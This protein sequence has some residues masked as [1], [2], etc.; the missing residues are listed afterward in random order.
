RKTS[1]WMKM[2]FSV[3]VKL[4]EWPKLSLMRIFQS[5]GISVLKRTSRKLNSRMLMAK[6]IRGSRIYWT[7]DEWECYPVGL[8]ENQKAGMTDEQCKELYRDFLA[9]LDLF[10]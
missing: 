1:V 4:R 9:D 7:W 10:R 5:L 2:K 6:L 8:Y 3:Y